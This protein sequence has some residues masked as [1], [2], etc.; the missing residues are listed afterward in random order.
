[1]STNKVAYIDR[2]NKDN[3]K[4]YQFR[5]RKTESELIDILDNMANRNSYITNLIMEDVK[6]SIL[7]IKEIKERI[8]PLIIK[9]NIKD[10]YLFGSYA[11]GEARRDSDIDILC[12]PGNV[13]GLFERVGMIQ[14]FEKSL[15]RK[16]D[17]VIIG[18]KMNDIF[19]E[20]IEKDKI[21]I[22]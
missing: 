13:K 2:Y 10:V 21:K 11:R 17:V 20:Q 1:M 22:C 15:E 19:K 6:P 7:T 18:S 4:M 16:V 9:Y 14:D 12:S 3:Y 8:A 5:V